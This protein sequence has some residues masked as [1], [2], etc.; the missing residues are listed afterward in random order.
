[1]KPKIT[2][3]RHKAGTMT[4]TTWLVAFDAIVLGQARREVRSF[5]TWL[6]A[7][8]FANERADHECHRPHLT[9]WPVPC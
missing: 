6:A 8:D 9:R 7:L 5:Y 4:V 1:M 3:A 2:S